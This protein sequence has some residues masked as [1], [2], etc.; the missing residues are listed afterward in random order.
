[1]PIMAQTKTFSLG[2]SEKNKDMVEIIAR[3]PKQENKVD[4][5]GWTKNIFK[6]K[7]RN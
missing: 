6:N 3:R 5:P 7:L 1:M 2:P 4:L